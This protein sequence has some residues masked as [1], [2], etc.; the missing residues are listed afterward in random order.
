MLVIFEHFLDKLE[1]GRFHPSLRS[2]QTLVFFLKGA[3]IHFDNNF[4]TIF[5][6]L[7]ERFSYKD[8]TFCLVYK[9]S[10]Y[11]IKNSN[12]CLDHTIL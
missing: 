6:F 9:L 12:A 3:M 2:G 11:D 1:S 4:Q 8:T 10:Q 5:S 7:M